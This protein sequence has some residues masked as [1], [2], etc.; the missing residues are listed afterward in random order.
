MPTF[1]DPVAD[2]AEAQQ[3]LRGLAHATRSVGDP[4]DAYQVMGSL[5][6]GLAS[7]EQSLTQLADFYAGPARD[8]ASLNGD[9]TAGRAAAQHVAEHLRHAHQLLA[10]AA[11]VLDSAH[12]ID[13]EITYAPE[14]AQVAHPARH[15]IA[16]PRPPQS[17]P[18]DGLLL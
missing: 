11:E 1:E 3:A 18:R 9:T 5:A 16:S 2:A 14:P 6:W 17:A 4:A 13:S 7:L 10:D 15:A 12:N 8:R